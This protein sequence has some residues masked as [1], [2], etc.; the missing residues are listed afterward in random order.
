[1]GPCGLQHSMTV[2]EYDAAPIYNEYMPSTSS[3]MPSTCIA[4]S[5]PSA[6]VGDAGNELEH[7]CNIDS[8][9]IDSL[10][11]ETF[12]ARYI[13]RNQPVRILLHERPQAATA[14]TSEKLLRKYASIKVGYHRIM[15][16]S[17]ATEQPL[18]LVVGHAGLDSIQ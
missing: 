1:M 7:I 9:H 17:R 3:D 14:F 8:V 6:Q 15:A 12:H 5:C 18:V 13:Q 11:V 16:A 2:D 10:S 4:S